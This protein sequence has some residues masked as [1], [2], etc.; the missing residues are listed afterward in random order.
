MVCQDDP[1]FYLHSWSWTKDT[2]IGEHPPFD[3]R[4]GADSYASRA[5]KDTEAKGSDYPPAAPREE[6]LLRSLSVGPGRPEVWS[7]VYVQSINPCNPISNWDHSTEY[8]LSRAVLPLGK[9]H[10]PFYGFMV[11]SRNCRSSTKKDEFVPRVF[12]SDRRLLSVSGLYSQWFLVK[13]ESAISLFLLCSS[14]QKLCGSSCPIR[15]I[16]WP[17]RVIKVFIF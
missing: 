4:L 14:S 16:T 10:Q 17:L 12:N 3:G 9:P 1:L 6:L 11:V 2:R 15:E 5:G 7:R 13:I 8:Q